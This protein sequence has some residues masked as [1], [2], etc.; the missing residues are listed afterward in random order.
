MKT[1]T[2][3]NSVFFREIR[4]MLGQG[5]TV[6]FSVKGESMRP[7]LEGGRDRVI[8]EKIVAPVEK[9][10]VVLAEIRPDV[11][12]L[13]RVIRIE[14]DRLWLMGDGN[15]KGMEQ[16]RIA[17]LVGVATG[18]QR[19]GRMSPDRVTSFKWKSYSACWRFLR[20]FR[21]WLLGAYRHVWL[22]LFPNKQ[23]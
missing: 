19:K 13:H 16:C 15:V 3:P 9:G 17:D 12:V 8:L 1:K 20:P 18:F 2:I 5:E 10:D 14:N 23:G 22:R 6:L 11:Y 4:L 21:R 7:F